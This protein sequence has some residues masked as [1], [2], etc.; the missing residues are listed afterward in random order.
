[1]GSFLV[2]VLLISLFLPGQIEAQNMPKVLYQ[3]K[4]T[5]AYLNVRSGAAKSYKSI[6]ILKKGAVVSVIQTGR[7]LRIKYR[8]GYG[9]V[10]GEY[11][12]KI[13]QSKPQSPKSYILN[14]PVYNQYPQLPRG[15][16]VTS[17]SM[18]LNYAGKHIDKMALAS[19]IAKVPYYS[20][21]LYGN[22]HDGFVGN[23][24]SLRYSG[25]GVYH[26]PVFNLAKRYLGSRA[27]DLSGQSWLAIEAQIRKGRPVWVIVNAWFRYLPGNQWRTWHTKRGYIRITMHEHSVLVTGYDAN[28]VYVNDPMGGKK[29]R[30]LGKGY[31]I[32][33]WQQMGSQAISFN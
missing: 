29:N 28:Y 31:F 26:E 15:C 6:G 9:F 7:W 19:Q 17:L 22:P 18:L 20:R 30:R 33:A 4:V 12:Q 3:G 23:M 1:M 10:S 21:G 11:V 16:E 32:S 8:N 24:Y 14:A 25:Y 5:T 27:V 13:V 2:I